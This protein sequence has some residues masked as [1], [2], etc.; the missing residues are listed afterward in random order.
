MKEAK[1][2]SIA[3]GRAFDSNAPSWLEAAESVHAQKAFHGIL[4]EENPRD[5]ADVVCYDALGDAEDSWTVS[6]PWQVTRY[7]SDMAAAAAPLLRASRD[8][9]FIE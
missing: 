6:K 9:L 8:I 1:R 3:S 4:S 5:H 2:K 7:R